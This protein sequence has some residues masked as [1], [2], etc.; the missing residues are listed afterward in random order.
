MSEER[1]G[2]YVEVKGAD[3]ALSDIRQLEALIKSI[4]NTKIN[5]VSNDGSV[6]V[7]ADA[8]LQVNNNLR[9]VQ[10]QS[11]VTENSLR[12]TFVHSLSFVRQLGSSLQVVG[13]TLTQLSSPLRG[14]MRGTLFAAGYKLLDSFTGG[15][16][17]AADRYDIIATYAP[18][19]KSIGAGLSDNDAK[20]TQQLQ[21]SYDKMYRSILG[22]PTG[23]GEMVDRF[24]LLTIAVQDY[25]RATELAIAENNAFVASATQ[26][27]VVTM[28]KKQFLTLMT[29]G[30]LTERQWIS[31][32]KGIPVAWN[33]IEKG[34]QDS[35]RISGRL[36]DAL[37]SGK[38]SAEE[39]GDALIEVSNSPAMEKILTQTKHTFAAA[40][41]NIGN[42]AKALGY[43]IINTLN[44]I[45]KK[46]Y[47]KDII[48]FLVDISTAIDNSIEPVKQ[49]LIDNSDIFTGFIDTIRGLDYKGFLS[50]LAEGLKVTAKQMQQFLNLF[51]GKGAK[52]FGYFM[53][54]AGFYG[55]M[56][57]FM[58]AILKGFRFP[59]A[60]L[61]TLSRALVKG[62]NGGGLL[63]F[64]DTI[65][66]GKNGT[67]KLTRATIKR[68]QTMLATLQ[69]IFQGLSGVIQMAGTVAIASGAAVVAFKAVKSS[70]KDL[71]EII[72]LVGEIDWDLG[73]KVIAAMTGFFSLLGGLGYVVGDVMLTLGGG[74][75]TLDSFKVLIG[76]GLIGAMTILAAGITKIDFMLIKSA[77]E[78]FR[79]ILTSLSD[80][81]D[82]INSLQAGSVDTGNISAVLG[83]LSEVYDMMKPQYE[84]TSIRNMSPTVA[85]QMASAVDSMKI[86]IQSLKDSADI[87]AN[88]TV[89]PDLTAAETNI[90]MLLGH[91]T[92]IYEAG[93]G[94]TKR[95]TPEKATRI[96]DTISEMVETMTI[97]ND[98]ML[99]LN[100]VGNKV[101]PL[102][103]L[104]DLIINFSAL[105]NTLFNTFAREE[106]LGEAGAFG[107]IT[108][109]VS[110]KEQAESMGNIV[111]MFQGIADIVTALNDMWDGM[112]G[113]DS[114]L[115]A[116]TAEWGARWRKVT[117]FFSTITEWWVSFGETYGDYAMTGVGNFRTSLRDFAEAI[118]FLDDIAVSL[119]EAVDA[120]REN[121]VDLATSL[122]SVSKF[123]SQINGVAGALD[124]VKA[125]SA[126]VRIMEMNDALTELKTLINSAKELEGGD[127]SLSNANG[128][129]AN[130]AEAMS[131]MGEQ[132]LAIGQAW[133]NSML[134]GM[135]FEGLGGEFTEGLEGLLGI[136]SQYEER[137]YNEG[138]R[139]GTKFRQGLSRN[140]ANINVSSSVT[141][142]AHLGQVIG[143]GT[144]VTSVGNRIRSALESTPFAANI[145][146]RPP[147]IPGVYEHFGGLVQY[148]AKGGSI[149]APRGT[150]TV[151][152]MGTPGEFM[153]RARAV[154][155][156]GLD[157]MRKVNS[158]DFIGAMH[159]LQGRIN[160]RL[161]GHSNGV[162][163]IVNHN[164]NQRMTM[165]VNTNNPNFAYKR[166]H[167][168][169]GAI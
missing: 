13:K 108:K 167:R 68:P 16:Q 87:L 26:G 1:V 30:K 9:A 77:M 18:I 39:F 69:G 161:S 14:I 104:Q 169:V 89:M 85:S 105:K 53:G 55:R 70:L 88:F 37:K 24:K 113:K 10:R 41:A 125:L 40:T 114:I 157:F 72:T 106:V 7:T 102:R 135:D 46:A 31:L 96:K 35:G 22:L 160:S 133:H 66:G 151:P 86:V 79:D 33:M 111:S 64:L 130:V 100:E 164:N 109:Q 95:K 3:S 168:Y 20:A 48:D 103:K 118:G 122:V 8:I 129:L 25:D 127:A 29:T 150:D 38:I 148:R 120:I 17:D 50:G 82:I 11:K 65:I 147:R 4:S 61:M 84:G 21:A 144:I 99:L 15:L 166:S 63:G 149:F 74:K 90:R 19:L 145:N 159:S 76:E 141:I 73:G 158:L 115:S 59:I 140:L 67:A 110:Y 27:N 165:N 71:K 28:A 94:L 154:D 83:V 32:Q 138:L 34:F 128:I 56:L 5:L 78:D 62:R 45:L 137:F 132:F 156:F 57:S 155:T 92:I 81:I 43:N 163:N 54:R 80:S 97:I 136:L 51:V 121:P 98:A 47:G 23:M 139:V 42:Y 6:Q 75:L 142:D 162:T 91:Y 58:G 112:T 36:I 134:N 12:T 60:G 101:F 44:D 107:K 52:T 117:G 2:I 153:M 152:I 124:G 49:W 123:I 131:Q 146:I 93:E 126:K 119:K 116:T 143:I